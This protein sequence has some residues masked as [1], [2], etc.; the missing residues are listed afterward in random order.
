M[1]FNNHDQNDI[2]KKKYV[3]SKKEV[4]NED[5]EFNGKAVGIFLEENIEAIKEIIA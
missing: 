4:F 3:I 5:D 1:S 2:N